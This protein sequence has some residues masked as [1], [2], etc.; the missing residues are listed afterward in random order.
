MYRNFVWAFVF[1]AV[2][3]PLASGLLF[4]LHIPPMFAG[5]AMAISSVTVVSSSL[6]LK[7]FRAPAMT[8]EA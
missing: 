5:T 2:G 8:D 1:N 6:L 4:P 3:I 7:W